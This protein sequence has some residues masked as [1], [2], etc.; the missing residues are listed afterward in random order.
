MKISIIVP[1]YRGNRYLKRLF[2][3]IENV[4]VATRELAQY[5]V[6]LVN[7][8]PD[9][10]VSVPG[11]WIEVKIVINE[12]NLGIQEA[13]INGLRHSLGEWI[14]FLDQDDELVDSGFKRQ[15]ELT[16]EAD[17]VV[18][19]GTYIL[20]S[21]NKQI[22]KNLNCMKYLIQKEM[23]IK[24]RN[25][26]PSPGECLIRKNVIPKLWTRHL[27]KNN[28]ADD[29]FLWLLLFSSGAKFVCNDERVYIHNDSEGENLSANLKKMRIS[30]NEMRT[31]LFK[32][33][34]I[35]DKENKRLK[36]SIE[37]KFLQDTGNLTMKRLLKYKDALIDNVV[38]K[39]KTSFY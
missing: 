2:T 36:H 39:I 35:S 34:M 1:F 12:K 22:Y 38:Y 6:I 27:L 26:I 32:E 13:R 19:N 23:F 14:V 31:I 9:C 10:K 17:I 7:D 11:T 8:S 16:K 4:A 15:I 25:L 3:S 21:V 18:G 37:F 30:S 33:M 5:E 29:W 28:G 24:I 20:G